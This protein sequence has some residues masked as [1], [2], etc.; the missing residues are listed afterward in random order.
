VSS[1]P[2]TLFMVLS[3]QLSTICPR[4]LF[5]PPAGRLF[6]ARPSFPFSD[7]VRRGRGVH[8]PDPFSLVGPEIEKRSAFFFCVLFP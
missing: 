7:S 8:L 5:F 1:F 2:F 3:S 4:V 6:E